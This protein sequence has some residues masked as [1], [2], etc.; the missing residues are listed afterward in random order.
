M[1]ARTRGRSGTIRTGVLVATLVALGVA[2]IGCTRSHYRARADRDVYDALDERAIDPRWSLPRRP[3]EASTKSRIGDPFNPDA[4]PIPLDDGAA[5]L[6]QATNGRRHEFYK[7]E[8]RGTAEV[9]DDA[10]RLC[11]STDKDGAVV[12]NRDSA[13]RLALLNSREYQL[14]VEQLYE[15]ALQLTLARYEF[16]LQP[17]ARQRTF[18]SQVGSGK[19]NQLQ[20]N[21]GAGFSQNF[22]S[23]G[24]LLVDFANAMVFNFNGHGF[25]AVTSNIGL[26]FTQPLLRGAFA[27]FRTQA[28]SLQERQTLYA[29]RNF[30]QFRRQFY[31]NVVARQGYLGLLEQVQ[32]IRNSEANVNALAR[33]V[34]ELDLLVRNKTKARTDR[35]LIAINY[36]S[37]QLSLIQSQVGLQTS[38]DGYKIQ[39]GLPTELNVTLD[40]SPLKIFE[41]NNPEI[42]VLR[43]ENETRFLALLQPE[44][45]PP[46]EEL[47]KVAGAIRAQYVRLG[48]IYAELEAELGRWR[49]KLDQ[50]GPDGVELP[51]PP[52]PPADSGMARQVV[53]SD[54]VRSELVDSR[55]RVGMNLE[56]LDAAVADLPTSPRAKSWTK[57][58]DILG[59]E[60]AGR[61]A[62]IRSSQTQTRVFLIELPPSDLTSEQAVSLGLQNRLDLMNARAAVT[63]AWR[64]EELAANRLLADVNVLYQG[65]LNTDPKRSGLFRFDAGDSTHRI[66]LQF[67]APLVRRAE[68]NAYRASQIGYQQARRNWMRSRDL[69]VQ[70]VRIDIRTLDQLRRQFEISREQLITSARQTEATEIEQRASGS[71][72]SS[73]TLVLL[74][75]LQGLLSAKNTLIQNWVSYQTIR[76]SL[77]RDLDLMDIDA[78]GVWLN[79]HDNLAR[80]ARVAGPPEPLPP[81]PPD[82]R[83]LQ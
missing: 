24:Q 1:N 54:R 10:W 82:G 8:K 59:I 81:E 50:V 31:V 13:I 25:D 57:L 34:E 49:A 68:R 55:L 36:Q 47:E 12:L 75:A 18:F 23:G 40:E 30:A 67:D 71:T 52:N 32:A 29:V 77:Y 20:L 46:I 44:I 38:L 17:L 35:D 56:A 4:D 74:Q 65:N 76:M 42:D 9:E 58:R 72:D 48:P 19:N 5:R 28:L 7:W 6:F 26:T 16:Y 83:P 62:D 53:L 61:I 22:A 69:V 51:L 60:F 15:A 80:T 33:N 2:M 78:Q 79:E 41:L 45:A 43:M 66:G 27:R 70:Q 11:V 39:L 37:S 64:N 14:Q 3:V 21:Q 63:D 73:N